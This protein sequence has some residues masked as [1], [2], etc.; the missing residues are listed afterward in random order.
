MAQG[1][2][3]NHRKRAV[4]AGVGA[5]VIPVIGKKVEVRLRLFD[6]Y[7]RNRVFIFLCGSFASYPAD[8]TLR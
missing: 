5:G 8:C 7:E 2:D 3:H 4:K 1:I 6:I